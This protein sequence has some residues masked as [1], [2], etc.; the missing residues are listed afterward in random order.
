MRLAGQLAPASEGR[1]V[2]GILVVR[3]EGLEVWNLGSVEEK[4]PEDLDLRMRRDGTDC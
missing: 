3:D 2:A 1:G 4:R